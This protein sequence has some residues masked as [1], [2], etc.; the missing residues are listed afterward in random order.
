MFVRVTFVA[1]ERA[2]SVEYSACVCI[3]AL[4]IRIVNHI[5]SVQYY[6]VIFG[7]FDSAIFFPII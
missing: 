1:V 2:K 6:V 5:F 4:V 3:L 7:L